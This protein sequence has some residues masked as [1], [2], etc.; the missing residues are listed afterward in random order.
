MTVDGEAEREVVK[1]LNPRC[2]LNQFMTRN[3]ICRRPGCGRPLKPEPLLAL[4]EAGEQ[5]EPVTAA[6]KR[7][8]RTRAEVWADPEF[9]R[10]RAE[11]MREVANRPEVK[12]RSAEAMRKR[13][14]DPEFRRR[15]AEAMREVANRPEVK[16][17][18]AEAMRKRW[19]DPEFRRRKAEAMRKRWAERK[20]NANTL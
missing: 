10:R 13:W 7:P 9:R 14:A 3:E 4:V 18:K 17:R 19:A 16:L 20:K 12:L 8:R 5:A 1:C 6:V 11:A 15:R 2:G